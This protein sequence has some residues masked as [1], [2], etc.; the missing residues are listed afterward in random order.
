MGHGRAEMA[1]AAA[2]Q[3]KELAYFSGYI[4]SSNVPA[5]NLAER[6]KVAPRIQA[7]MTKRGLVTRTLRAFGPHPALGESVLF[8]P[9]LVITEAE[10][11]RLV[12]VAQEAVNAVLGA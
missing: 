8:A 6:L 9:P 4:G 12:S 1:E 7:E 3:M 10:V 11:D 5:I 2:A